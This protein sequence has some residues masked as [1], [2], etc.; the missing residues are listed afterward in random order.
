VTATPVPL[1]LAI[2]LLL[3]TPPAKILTVLLEVVAP[4]TK[5]PPD[6]LLKLP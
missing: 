5:L 3:L 4:I 1:T 6:V 2:K